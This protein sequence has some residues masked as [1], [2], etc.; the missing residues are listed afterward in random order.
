MRQ[1]RWYRN[2]SVHQTVDTVI[3]SRKI[4]DAPCIVFTS[5]TVCGSSIVRM[6]IMGFIRSMRGER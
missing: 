5:A 1:T 3:V 2:A 6:A 4:N